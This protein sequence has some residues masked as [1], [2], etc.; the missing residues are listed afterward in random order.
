MPSNIAPNLSPPIQSTTSTAAALSVESFTADQGSQSLIDAPIAA[1]LDLRPGELVEVLGASKI[2]ASLDAEGKL[3]GLPFMPEMLIFCGRR[4]HVLKRA[5]S[6]CWRGQPRKIESA[7]HLEQIRCDGSAHE[8]CD[9]ACLLLWKE[10]WLRRVP[11]GPYAPPAET[12]NP[13]STSAGAGLSH[14]SAAKSDQAEAH[15][16]VYAR[17]KGPD[18]TMMC[19]A[20]E[21][22]VAS[23]PMMLGNPPRCFS[24]VIRDRLS[25]KISFADLRWLCVY[26]RGKLILFLFTRW[27][28]AAWNA[29][30]Y[31]R[32]P[33]EIFSLKPGEWVEVRS[34]REI[35]RTLDNRACNKGMEFKAEMFQF[36][37]RR[38]QVL[39]RMERRIDEHTSRMRA[40][41]NECI[42]LDRVHCEGQRSF[43]ARNNYH[44]WREIW[45]RRC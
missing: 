18:E 39:S 41:R 13:P 33:S 9:A 45:L 43:C 2:I 27:A 40:F 37:G 8:A 23:C 22:G 42:I 14:A 17:T 28:R 15:R 20:T 12:N 1:P 3:D 25:G 29:G 35:L 36:C 16:P 34:A 11:T 32:T 19:Q 38:F 21:I 31:K 44:Y 7:V 26:F 5:D 6:T 30:R 10:A 24:E 4:L